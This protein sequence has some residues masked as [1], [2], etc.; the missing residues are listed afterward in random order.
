MESEVKQKGKLKYE[1]EETRH[2]ELLLREK[3]DDE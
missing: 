3:E 2:R 1:R